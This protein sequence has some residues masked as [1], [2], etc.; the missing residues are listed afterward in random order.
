MPI[1]HCTIIKVFSSFVKNFCFFLVLF[2][3]FSIFFRKAI[4]KIDYTYRFYARLR[5]QA[6]CAR[7][8]IIIIKYRKCCQ[9][10]TK[11]CQ[12]KQKAQGKPHAYYAIDYNCH[13]AK[14]SFNPKIN[15]TNMMTGS[16]YFIYERIQRFTL[17][18]LPWLASFMKLS[19][20]QPC[21]SLVQNST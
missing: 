13:Q 21:F 14:N 16:T 11:K 8:H 1:F 15:T 4:E 3:L 5:I 18:P 7:T 10:N 17:R 6:H 20:P 12:K 9:K 2:S 19:K